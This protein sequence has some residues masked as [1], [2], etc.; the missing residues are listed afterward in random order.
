MGTI[1]EIFF[2]R[3]FQQCNSCWSQKEEAQAQRWLIQHIYTG[4]S[5]VVLGLLLISPPKTHLAEPS[6][7]DHRVFGKK[8]LMPE[9]TLDYDWNR[10]MLEGG[11]DFPGLSEDSEN[12]ECYN[13]A[14]TI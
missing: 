10:L 9:S 5:R 1:Y 7:A 2:C 12:N 8:P 11:F 3:R 4:A 14:R 6:C 13:V